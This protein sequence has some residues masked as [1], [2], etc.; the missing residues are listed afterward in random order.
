MAD[1]NLCNLLAPVSVSDAIFGRKPRCAARSRDAGGDRGACNQRAFRILLFAADKHLW[2]NPVDSPLLVGFPLLL[3]AT[4]RPT[5]RLLP[6]FETGMGMKPTTTERTPPS[7]KHTFLLQ[8]AG[9]KRNKHKSRGGKKEER[10]KGGKAISKL[11]QARRKSRAGR[12]SDARRHFPD[13][14]PVKDPSLGKSLEGQIS[15]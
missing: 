14:W 12:T 15:N 2:S 1:R 7:R 6:F 13:V 9:L 8:H 5:T 11:S 10:S 3:L 4:L